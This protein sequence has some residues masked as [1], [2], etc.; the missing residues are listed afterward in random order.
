MHDVAKAE[1]VDYRLAIRKYEYPK[2]MLYESSISIAS[3]S[4]HALNG[5]SVKCK[6]IFISKCVRR[7][8]SRISILKYILCAYWQ[9][10]LYI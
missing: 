7:Y 8:L 5:N 4:L 1:F 6:R 9:Q 3:L 2:D 10:I